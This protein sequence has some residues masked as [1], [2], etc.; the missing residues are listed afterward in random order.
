W[1]TLALLRHEAEV[2][3]TAPA[4]YWHLFL[5]T[6]Y[7]APFGGVHTALGSYKLASPADLAGYL[8]LLPAYTA[9]VEQLRRHLEGQQARGILMP[10]PEV[11]TVAAMLRAYARPPRESAL[12]VS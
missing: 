4:V 12:A 6:P 9:M 7:D 3:I 5:A 8:R 11:D 1:L 2:S 10:K